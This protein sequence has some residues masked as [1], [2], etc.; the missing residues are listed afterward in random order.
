MTFH[1]DIK[2]QMRGRGRGRRR[3]RGRSFC[4]TDYVLSK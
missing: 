1:L 4:K 3:E 2:P